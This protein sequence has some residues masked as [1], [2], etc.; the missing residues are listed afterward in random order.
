MDGVHDLGGREGFGPVPNKQDDVPFH[1]DWEARAF[2]I[3][4]SSA[5]G[6][7][8]SIDWFRHCRETIVPTDYLTRP[9]FDQWITTLAAQFV[10]EGYI[11]LAEIKSGKSS[12]LP[13]PAYAADT[14]EGARNY[15]MDPKSYSCEVGTVALFSRGDFVR[16][17]ALGSPG[18][19]RL[20]GYVRG[21]CGVVDAHH[22]AHRLPDASAKGG[23]RAEHLYT[24]TFDASELWPEA[25]DA[26]DQVFVDLWE[27][28]LEP[29]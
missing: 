9:Y 7:G 12:F 24:V 6:S 2:G 11:T 20:P 21:R 10:D 14:V 13:E 16:C 1:A 18:H 29:A 26:V 17:S 23:G 8:W 15:V 28:Y 3:V 22:G 19:T 5:L 25:T 27:N 4:Q